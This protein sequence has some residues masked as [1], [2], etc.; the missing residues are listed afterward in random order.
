MTEKE[1]ITITPIELQWSE[2]FLWTELE[3]DA[4]KG[5]IKIPNEVPGVYEARYE[6]EEERL[7]IGKTSDLRRRIKE[8][9]I[10]GKTDHSAGDRLREKEDVSKI[11]VRWAITDRPSCVEEE[12]HRRHKYKFGKLPRHVKQT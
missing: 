4:R 5:G 3:L 8:G 7:D 11:V 10:R 9:L 6:E 2:W 1:T 12:L